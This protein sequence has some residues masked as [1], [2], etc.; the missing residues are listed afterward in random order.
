MSDSS[1]Q[2]KNEPN[3]E[4]H[5]NSDID[6]SENNDVDVSQEENDSP[7][8]KKDGSGTQTHRSSQS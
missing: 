1:P 6:N 3:Q 8:I 2:I 5:D 4:D 7:K